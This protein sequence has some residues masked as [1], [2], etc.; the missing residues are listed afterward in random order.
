MAGW[1]QRRNHPA[2]VSGLSVRDRFNRQLKH[3]KCTQNQN[4]SKTKVMEDRFFHL[5]GTFK[6][7]AALSRITGKSRRM[8]ERKRISGEGGI[9]VMKYDILATERAA[10]IEGDR[11]EKLVA[12]A[13]C[14]EYRRGYGAG[15]NF[16]RK[17]KNHIDV[18]N[19]LETYVE[20]HAGEYLEDARR[21]VAESVHA[22]YTTKEATK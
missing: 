6:S 10:Q 21:V 15:Y 1:R 9:N 19:G 16:N 17:A 14:R 13:I 11:L 5:V 4:K 22:E 3:S 2:G 20:E 8:Y 7:V 12:R 18:E